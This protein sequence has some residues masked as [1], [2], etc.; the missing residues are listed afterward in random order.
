[1]TLRL[2]KGSVREENCVEEVYGKK[3]NEDVEEDF[4]YLHTQLLS[5]GKV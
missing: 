1:V 4:S 3:E 2:P 5:E